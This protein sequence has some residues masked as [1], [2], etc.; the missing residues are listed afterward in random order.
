MISEAT[1]RDIFDF[2]RI[3][4]ISWSGRLDESDFLARLFDL[5]QLPSTDGRFSDASGDIWQHR[6]NNPY[7]WDDDWVFY[8]KRFDLLQCADDIFL[9]FLCESVH[10]A[11]RPDSEE[12]LRIV[13]AFNDALMHDGYKIISFKKVSGRN[14][15]KGCKALDDARLPV[16]AKK[17]H[18]EMNSSYILSQI[19]RM[20]SSIL[21]DPENSIGASKEFIETICKTILFENDVI[22]TEKMDFNTLTKETRKILHILPGDVDNN[23]KGLD[24]IKKVLQSASTMLD[25]LGEIRNLYGTGHGKVASARGLEPRHARLAVGIAS[26][27]GRFFFDCHE[28]QKETASTK[29]LSSSD[30]TDTP[31]PKRPQ[32]KDA[33][34]PS[35]QPI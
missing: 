19:E 14:Y 32:E 2:F 4:Q 1:R 23:K 6:V 29:S 13:N 35:P 9:K 20:E 33:L 31:S 7:D 28:R 26:T 21:T 12:S 25:G 8:D 34:P 15:Y 5:Q 10:P 27:L 30:E 16:F 18:L 17:L 24:S 3:E 22:N 11:V